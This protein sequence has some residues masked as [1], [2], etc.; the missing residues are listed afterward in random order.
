MSRAPSCA[1]EKAINAALI[2]DSC[3]LVPIVLRA[4]VKTSFQSNFLE[5]S[6][7]TVQEL[8]LRHAAGMPT[9]L[10]GLPSPGPGA[11]RSDVRT[12]L[13]PSRDPRLHQVMFAVQFLLLGSQSIQ[14]RHLVC[15]RNRQLEQLAYSRRPL[16][17]IRRQTLCPWPA[18]SPSRLGT[19]SLRPRSSPAQ[20]S[21]RP[22]R[23]LCKSSRLPR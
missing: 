6:R 3:L 22:S 18:M 10:G 11:R 20:R 14:L 21:G 15:H 13:P 1:A 2:P 8:A 5:S 7:P 16:R 9:K 4:C 12:P 19:C 23:D 17:R